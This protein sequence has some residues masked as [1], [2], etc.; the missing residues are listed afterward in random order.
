MGD[1]MRNKVLTS[2]ALV[3]LFCCVPHLAAQAQQQLPGIVIDGGGGPAGPVS[4]GRSPD[5]GRL[6]TNAAQTTNPVDTSSIIPQD[7][8]NYAGAGN[9]VVREQ[10]DEQ[11]PLTNHEALAR[12][13]GIIT[14]TDDGLARHGGVGIRGSNFRRS[15]KVLIMEDGQS[16]N[17]SSYI[18]PSTHYTPPMERVENIEVIRGTV[19]SHGPL[20][21][22]GVINFQNLNPFGKSETVIKGALSYNEDSLREV[23]NSRHIHTRQNLGN[24]G[25]VASYS[26][27]EGAGAWDNERL[28]YNDFYGALGLRG[29]QQDLTISG[30]YFRQRDNYDED[31]FVGTTADF[32]AN[33]RDK[34][35]VEDDDRTELNT[36][37]ADYWRLQIAHN[38][39]LTDDI[40][41]ST[42]LYGS[43]HERNRFSNRRAALEDGGYMRGR[44]RDYE[45]YG[46]D[47]R[48]EFANLPLF[49]G[50]TQDVQAGVRYEHHKFVNCTSFGQESEVLNTNN[51]GNCRGN[52]VYPTLGRT[53]TS[54]VDVFEA[55]A[56][57]AFIQTA[58]HLTPNFTVTPG[59]RFE[60]YKVEGRSEF[61]GNGEREESDHTHVLP[62]VAMAWEFMPRWTAF[63][64]Y[65]RG[66]APHVVRDV[67]IENFPLEDEVGD[68]FQ[69]GLRSSAV[70]GLT[71]DVAYFHS[72]I[73]N[74]QVKDAFTNDRGENVFGNLDEVQFNGVELGIRAESRPITG[75]PWNLFGEVVYTFTNSDIRKGS[76][77]LF[78]DLPLQDVSGNRVPFAVAHYANLTAGIAYKKIWDASMTVTYRG[79][80]FSNS[81]NTGLV[82]LDDDENVDLG[83]TD[84]AGA[85]LDELLGGKV[86]DVWLLS[87]RANYNVTDQLSLFVSGHN[88]TDEF[89]VADVAD[90]LKPG[91]GRTLLGGFTL[92]FD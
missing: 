7:F 54:E 71:F 4:G 55:N 30:G 15:R 32:F 75:G 17:Y 68:N 13:P 56:F 26:G 2:T 59:V 86:D 70:R 24:V 90:G 28:R 67:G 20:T 40:T 61:G 9:R 44:N 48:I 77:A 45:V 81:Q 63:A 3:A 36:F 50:V 37:N 76:D 78:E 31:N 47:S 16:I 23:G 49:A 85:G 69:I 46:A 19:V 38:A 8:Q 14:Y 22:H 5:D 41:L 58:I 88:L 72:I 51:T 91:Q 57:S 33:G 92:K 21:N 87:A 62:G 11:R 43:D 18:D 83:C 82:C 34:T 73:E 66:F 35:G 80:F 27:A 60:D 89:Y 12:V 29:S 52:F 25:V 84:A 6:T 1:C 74:Y 65:H 42:R 10:I 79:D 64:G 53:E 39:Y